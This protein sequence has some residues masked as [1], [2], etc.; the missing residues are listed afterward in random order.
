MHPVLFTIPLFGGIPIATYGVLVATAFLVGMLWVKYEARRV[1]A[2][3]EKALDLVFYIII[4][5]IV[6]SRVLHVIVA[7]FDRFLANPLI[8]FKFWEGGLV[9]YG[10]FLAS[11]AVGFWFLWKHHLPPL[12]YYDIFTPALS[13]GHAIGR[14]GCFFAG[15]CHGRPT[16]G[17]PWYAVVFPDV[18]RSSAPSGIPLYPTQLMESAGEF[19]IFL[20]LLLVRSRKKFDGQIFASY[21]MAYAVLRS[22]I[23][24][25]RG[26]VERGF[27][28]D[29]WLSTSQFISMVIFLVGLSLFMVQTKKRGAHGF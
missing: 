1:G 25:F 3:P 20:L 9:F 5:A 13:L 23:E 11:Q 29:P 7:D 24:Y 19:S 14:I 12:V 22:T 18:A 8:L 21:L 10:G 15:C 16:P 27:V 17:H 4:A 26:D 6:G 28:I 2:D